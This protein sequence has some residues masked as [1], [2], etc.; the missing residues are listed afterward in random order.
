MSRI[1]NT[2]IVFP[3]IASKDGFA[4]TIKHEDFDI[5]DHRFDPNNPAFDPLS[6]GYSDEVAPCTKDRRTMIHLNPANS[7]LQ[8][9]RTSQRFRGNAKAP[10]AKTTAI[11]S[12]RRS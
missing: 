7:R 5:R 11:I 10:D 8:E 1:R 12:R 9:T 3:R 4:R 6:T 2:S